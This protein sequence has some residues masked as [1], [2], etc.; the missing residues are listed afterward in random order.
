MKVGEL[1]LDF[2][3]MYKTYFPNNLNY[4]ESVLYVKDLKEQKTIELIN[5]FISFWM[6]RIN[7][8][9]C[10]EYVLLS[11]IHSNCQGEQQG[12]YHRQDRV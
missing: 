9:L 7:L 8:K 11:P 1:I 10:K 12:I 2:Y 5:L 6:T 3:T 4:H